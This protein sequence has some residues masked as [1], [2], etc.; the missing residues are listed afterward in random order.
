MSVDLFSKM[1]PVMQR[2]SGQE[3]SAEI[4]KDIYF[5]GVVFTECVRLGGSLG[6][7]TSFR[8]M[9]QSVLNFVHISP[10][11]FRA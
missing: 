8:I 2:D 10:L 7:D 4:R 11:G 5:C 6:A 3:K 9:L 1:L